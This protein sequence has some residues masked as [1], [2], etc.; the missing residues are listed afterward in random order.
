MHVRSCLQE[1]FFHVFS[2]IEALAMVRRFLAFF[3]LLVICLQLSLL[4]FFSN[5]ASDYARHAGVWLSLQREEEAKFSQWVPA[6]RENLQSHLLSKHIM[7]SL[8]PLPVFF[9]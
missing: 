4:F 6:Y 2:F 1:A 7:A 5:I 9:Y 8:P 3:M